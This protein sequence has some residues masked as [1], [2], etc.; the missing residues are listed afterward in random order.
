[1]KKRQS[2]S[3]AIFFML[4]TVLI[5]TGCGSNSTNNGSNNNSNSNNSSN[6][7]ATPEQVEEVSYPAEVSVWTA[8]NGNVAAT[9]SN[10]NEIGAYKQLEQITGT[11]ATFQHPPV[12]QE[13]EQFNL[14]LASGKLPDV[15]EYSW[16]NAPK[17]ADSLIKEGRILRLNELIAEHAPNLTKFLDENPELRKMLTTDEGNIY[18]MPFLHG[19]ESLSVT[20]GPI[21]REDWLKK[22]G[23]EQPTTI[24]QWEEMLIAFRDG[25]PNDN[26]QADEIPFL[27]TMGDIDINHLFV[28][29]WGI[30]TDFYQE[31]G[32]IEYGPIQPEFQEFLATIT[33]WYKE[34]LIDRDYATTDSK[35]KDAKVTG[36]QLGA[37]TGYPGG[38]MGRYMELMAESD[39]NF[40]LIGPVNPGSEEGGYAMG[41]YTNPFSGIGAAV[42]ATAENPEQIIKWLDYKYSEE[43]GLLF[44]F[45]IEGESYTMV[46]GYPTYTDLILNNP[47]GLPMTQAMA[48]Y[49][50]ANFSGPFIQDKRYLEQYYLLEQQREANVNW[51]KADHAKLLPPLTLTAE[52]SSVTASIMNDVK[53]YRDEMINKFIMGAEP[54][55]NFDKFVN[56]IESMGIDKV[57]EVR[58]EALERYNAR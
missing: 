28:G 34:G 21:I 16:Q 44:N 13:T 53:T 43:G 42:A 46:D 41:H 25:D 50:T 40:S 48:K 10:N 18:V 45:G 7:T 37:F 29:A 54:I 23:L 4:I 15:I 58:Q 1:M 12:G 33:K 27:L 6:A 22:L 31:D 14:M 3:K 32:K 47:D 9:M 8:L 51:S 36:N 39:P 55:E 19:D 52:E 20:H 17:G 49:F 35:L 56:T 24:A 38:G 11:K 2:L 26:G 5:I 30:T 57:I